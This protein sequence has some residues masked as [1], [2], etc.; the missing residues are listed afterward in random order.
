MNELLGVKNELLGAWPGIPLLDASI[1]L[2]LTSLGLRTGP[3][4][5]LLQGQYHLFGRGN[6]FN[7]RIGGQFLALGRVNPVGKSTGPGKEFPASVSIIASVKKVHGLI[8]FIFS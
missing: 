1:M 7:G 2:L 3:A 4:D 5:V 6:N 8:N